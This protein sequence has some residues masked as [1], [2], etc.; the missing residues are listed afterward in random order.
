MNELQACEPVIKIQNATELRLIFIFVLIF[1]R[2]V[3]LKRFFR[4]TKYERRP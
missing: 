1:T 2:I 3:A 4:I